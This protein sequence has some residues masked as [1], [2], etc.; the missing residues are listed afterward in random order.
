MKIK[1]IATAC[2]AFIFAAAS[3]REI[4]ESPVPA[5]QEA[6]IAPERHVTQLSVARNVDSTPCTVSYIITTH[7][8]GRSES[9]KSTDCEE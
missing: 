8:N 3:A 9:R 4:A 7:R 2:S 5:L 6:R 1:L